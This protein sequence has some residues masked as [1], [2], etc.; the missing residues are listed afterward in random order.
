MPFAGQVQ[1]VPAAAVGGIAESVLAIAGNMRWY[2]YAM[3]K[4]IDRVVD[5]AMT[6]K[7]G[8]GVTDLEV[9]SVAYTVWI[10]HP[11]TWFLGYLAI[12][13]V[14]RFCSAAFTGGVFGSLPLAVLDRLFFVPFRRRSP[15]PRNVAV[16]SLN[17]RASFLDMICE[18]KFLSRSPEV[19]D[20]IFYD[21]IA[22]EDFLEIHACRRKKDWV[23]PRVVRYQDN[24]YRLEN[25]SRCSNPRS[26]RYKLRRLEAGVPG[27]TV[28]LYTPPEAVSSAPK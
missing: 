16:S 25:C 3:S 1:W 22:G 27:R 26:F 10:T 24:F 15:E 23:P 11:L 9:G 20:D 13:G 7:L 2:S 12:E 19:A 28:L 17:D 18:W 5:V 4:M 8:P 14:V 21:R 6:G